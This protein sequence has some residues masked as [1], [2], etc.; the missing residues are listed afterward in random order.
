MTRKDERGFPYAHDPIKVRAIGDFIGET[1]VE[2]AKP[3][4]IE[5]SHLEQVIE[6]HPEY[7]GMTNGEYW[8]VLAH[9]A[10]KLQA[11]AFEKFTHLIADRDDEDEEEVEPVDQSVMIKLFPGITKAA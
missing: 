5:P 9:A 8:L 10:T 3:G 11:F 2:M 1:L 4:E 7:S 6:T